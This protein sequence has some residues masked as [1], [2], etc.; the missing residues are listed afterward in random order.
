MAQ[1]DKGVF[2]SWMSY[3]GM[4]SNGALTDRQKVLAHA[5]VDATITVSAEV[6]NVRTI[7]ITLR[8]SRG[9][10]IDTVTQ[11]DLVVLLN[12]S[13]TDFAATGGSTGIAI[14]ASGKLLTI[15]AKKLFRGISTAAGVMQVT[16]TDTGNEAAYLGVRLPNGNVILS[17]AL[18]NA[19]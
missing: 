1:R 7:D 15:V 2:G 4:D 12:A 8:D 11:V 13:G 14:G 19:T 3:F 16:W 10:A 9:R 6:T 5:A 18:T 17:S